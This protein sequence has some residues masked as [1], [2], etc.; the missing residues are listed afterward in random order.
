MTRILLIDDEKMNVEVMGISLRSDGYDV[1]TASSG[2]EGLEIFDRNAPDIVI[3][4]LKMPGMDGIEVLKAIKER[5]DA[6]EVIIITGH[7]DVENAIEALKYGASDFINKPVRDENLALALKRAES[8]IQIR[9]KLNAYTENLEKEVARVT[10]ELRM[11]SNF[12]E[13]LIKTS[14]EGIVATDRAFNVIIYNPAAEQILG[15]PAAEVLEKKKA[16]EL[17]SQDLMRKYQAKRHDLQKQRK[18]DHFETHVR[19]RDGNLVP[20]RFTG[21]FLY[22]QGRIMGSVAFLEDLSEIKRLQKELLMSERLCTVGQTVA[23]MAHGVKNI[24]HGFKGDSYLMEIGFKNNDIEKLKT[25][26]KMI[27]KHIARTSELVMDLL[28]YSKVRDPEYKP[29]RPNEIVQEACQSLVQTATEHNVR[30]TEDLDAG[31][32]ELKMDGNS[33][34]TILMNLVSNAIDA[35]IFDASPEKSHKVT[36]KTVLESARVR[37][38]VTDNG[39]GMTPEVQ[40]KI[41]TSF[42]STKGHRGTGLGLLVS[43]KLIEDHNGTIDVSSEI[44]KGTTFIVG[45]PFGEPADGN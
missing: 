19:N 3:T 17:F 32:G 16:K 44:G 40:E 31:I 7:G 28:T 6:A 1:L 21:V 15:Y 8:K 23:G 41:F 13:K 34:H 12:L 4:D 14:D 22:E 18:L 42:F 10:H 39:T 29:C 35:C 11:Q 26:W 37:F 25:G 33:I 30:I 36:V 2:I 5:S 45:L 27:Q 43:G 24:L 9:A 20:V 38:E